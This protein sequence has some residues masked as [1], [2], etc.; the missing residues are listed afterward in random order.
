MLSMQSKNVQ[1]TR[2]T[3]SPSSFLVQKSSNFLQNY[4]LY[5]KA[6]S[7]LFLQGIRD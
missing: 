4:L 2:K 6:H 1:V 5:E 3:S 7:F